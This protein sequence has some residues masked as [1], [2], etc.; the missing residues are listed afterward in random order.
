[1]YMLPTYPRF[2]LLNSL[3]RDKT[4]FRKPVARNAVTQQILN[5]GYLVSGQFSIVNTF[6]TVLAAVAIS[7]DSVFHR[8]SCI[9]VVRIYALSFTAFM[10][11][12][13]S[14]PL[15]VG[16]TKRQPV[17]FHRLTIN[18]QRSVT[19]SSYASRPE[20][21]FRGFAALRLCQPSFPQYGIRNI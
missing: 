4:E 16:H 9:Q 11:N 10:Q 6:S 3:G 21:T 2:D 14:W 5:L 7:V 8:R 19:L 13:L 20:P 1:M 12:H 15:T 18:G 17:S